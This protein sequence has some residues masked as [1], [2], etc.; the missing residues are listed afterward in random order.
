[1]KTLN[2]LAD[3]IEK[4][5]NNIDKLVARVQEKVA[6]KTCNDIKELAP[7]NGPYRESIKVYPTEIQNNVITTFV[8]SDMMVGPAKVNGNSYNLGY[9][10]EHGTLE[11]AIPNAFN[12]GVIYGFDSPQYART[13][14]KD[15]HPGSIAIPHYAIALEKN[16]KFYKDNIHYAWRDK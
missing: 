7:G 8:G 14:E 12:W 15:W 5:A 6:E 9:L 13:L 2:N 4:K 3:F 10:L 11:H 1:M 16:K